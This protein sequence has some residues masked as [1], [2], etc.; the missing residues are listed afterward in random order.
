[1]TFAITCD[2]SHKLVKSNSPSRTSTVTGT[3]SLAQ[4]A[5]QTVFPSSQREKIVWVDL[6]C[7]SSIDSTS[8]YMSDSKWDEN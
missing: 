3:Q 6:S 2:F 7:T 8:G 5:A 1:M 4:L